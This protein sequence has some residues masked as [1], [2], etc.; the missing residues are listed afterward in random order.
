MFFSGTPDIET[1]GNC[2][3]KYGENNRINKIE[4]MDDG[5]AY[6]NVNESKINIYPNSNLDISGDDIVLNKGMMVFSKTNH[7]V[8][9]IKT[10][11][12]FDRIWGGCSFFRIGIPSINQDI[13]G[14][15]KI[16]Y[17]LLYKK[18]DIVTKLHYIFES[19]ESGTTYFGFLIPL[20]PSW[21]TSNFDVDLSIYENIIRCQIQRMGETKNNLPTKQICTIEKY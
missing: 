16:T 17:Y 2:N 19:R 12:F 1:Y 7:A 8:E 14:Q 10:V 3:V 5:W 9:K 11:M 21:K 6:Y 15:V 4:T 13:T 20:F 18:I